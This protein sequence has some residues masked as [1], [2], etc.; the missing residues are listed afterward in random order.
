MAEACKFI[1]DTVFGAQ[2]KWIFLLNNYCNRYTLN[3]LSQDQGHRFH[4]RARVNL[5]SG[6]ANIEVS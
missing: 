6:S 5:A 1:L 2:V 4:L 3:H